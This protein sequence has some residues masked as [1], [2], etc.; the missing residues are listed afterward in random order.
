MLFICLCL[1][2][3]TVQPQLSFRSLSPLDISIIYRKFILFNHLYV[4]MYT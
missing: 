4:S 2:L 3:P 1:G